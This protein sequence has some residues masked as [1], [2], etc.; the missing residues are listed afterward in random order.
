MRLYA[1]TASHGKGPP[2]CNEGVH[3]RTS[4]QSTGSRP[5]SQSA[6]LP[7]AYFQCTWHVPA[8]GH[9][10]AWDGPFNPELRRLIEE[11]YRQHKLIAAVDHGPAVL[12]NAINRRV[13]DPDVGQPILW[14]KQVRGCIWR[15]GWEACNCAPVVGQASTSTILSGA[16]EWVQVTDISSI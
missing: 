4:V 16:W 9:G 2:D 11:A 14:R 10:I 12:V 6:I 5:Q 1:L 15:R 13:E 8:G 3:L 7:A